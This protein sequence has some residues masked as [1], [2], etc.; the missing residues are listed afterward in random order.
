M[1]AAPIYPEWCE[2][3]VNPFFASEN[4]AGHVSKDQLHIAVL[5]SFISIQTTL[6]TY[7]SLLFVSFIDNMKTVRHAF[8]VAFSVAMHRALMSDI[9]LS[10]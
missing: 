10:T 9:L 6:A 3:V 1:N 5:V 8:G 7:L 4:G 2:T